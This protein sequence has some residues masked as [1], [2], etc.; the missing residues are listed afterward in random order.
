MTEDEIEHSKRGPSGAHRWRACP[1]SVEEEANLRDTA[2]FFAAEGTAF[3]SFAADCLELG[4][5]PFGMIGST[6]EVEPHGVFEL[7][8]T[9]ANHMLAGLDIVWSYADAPGAKLI[10]E[11][12]VPLDEWV[13]PGELGTMDAGVIDVWNRRFV[14]FDWKYGAGVPV[15]PIWNDQ[16]ILY[17]LGAWTKWG[18][19]AFRGIDPREIEVIIIIE[20][21]RAPGGGGVWRTT[22]DVLL[23]EGVKIRA[24]ADRTL[25][26]G[27]PRVPG[28][29]QCKFCKAAFHNTCQARARFV[30][31]TVGS[32]FDTLE[33]QFHLGESF[34]LIDARALSPEARSQILLNRDLIEGFLQQLHDEA[35]RDAELGNPVPGLK[36]VLGRNPR[37]KW[38]D[39]EKVAIVLEREFLDDAY[40]KKL[41]SP[42]QAED[43]MG[44]RPF[45]ARFSR[46]V[47]QGEP[48]VIL[49][50]SDDKREALSSVHDKF[51]S[52]IETE[53]DTLI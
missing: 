28:I 23:R 52:L 43:L 30:L 48:K 29:P 39:E 46:H 32:K 11:Q 13:G 53:D 35:V 7:D 20:Q 18:R 42:A 9:M 36:R 1:G 4:I 47:E 50:P 5:E 40:V 19:D 17:T 16:G 25:I 51:D 3:H 41:L 6:M 2:G 34:D 10:V 27:A 14:T 15:S 33:D 21:P 24:D 38:Q 31:D 8:R 37:R 44:K 49:V 45:V 12:K 26:P 22:M